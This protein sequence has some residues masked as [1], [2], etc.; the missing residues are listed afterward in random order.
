[1]KVLIGGNTMHD[2]AFWH[3]ILENKGKV[4]K[5]ASQTELTTELLSYLH[6]P[7]PE[8]RDE[9]AYQILAHWIMSGD[10]DN[11]TLADF[12]D[13]WLDDLQIG[14]GEIG[15]DTVLIRSFASLMLSIL[16]YYDMKQSWLSEGDYE[17]LFATTCAYFIAEKD[18]R[19][20]DSEK[21]W[22]HTTAH[23]ADV[24][25]FLARD[26]KS[27]TEHLQKILDSIVTKLT[28][29]QEH[30]YTH[31]EDERIALVILEIVKRGLLDETVYIQWLADLM[32]VKDKL[33]P[34]ITLDEPAFGAVQNVTHFLR[35]LYFTLTKH[36]ADV[37]DV[38]KLE[39]K[40]FEILIKD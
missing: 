22:Y 15:T 31:G 24:L 32:I 30:I 16:V 36:R 11:E 12:L 9:F 25:K 35:A 17:R 26:K 2:K 8:L 40:V 20:Y 6:S 1:M 23:T 34:A 18:L 10:Y 3:G 5:G 28:Q 21:G 13:T 4:P 29:P 27:T 37:K 33:K 38:G 39:Y 7:D 19:S 14:L